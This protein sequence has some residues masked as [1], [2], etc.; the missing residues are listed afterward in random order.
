MSEGTSLPVMW[1]VVVNE[2]RSG[3]PWPVATIEGR[4]DGH[5]SLKG[6][7][8]AANAAFAPLFT[9]A[10]HVMGLMVLPDITTAILEAERARRE[11]EAGGQEA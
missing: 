8:N 7:P 2:Q 6:G 10:K 9:G 1:S 3:A 11:M 5:V 4:S